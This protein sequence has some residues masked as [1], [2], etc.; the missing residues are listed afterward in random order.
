MIN[1]YLWEIYLKSGGNK[2][3]QFFEDEINANLSM[4]YP[5]KLK[6][7]HKF[8][9][10]DSNAINETYEDLRDLQKNLEFDSTENNYEEKN[11]SKED[12]DLIHKLTLEDCLENFKDFIDE[13]SQVNEAYTDKE[14]FILFSGN[15]SYFSTLL[16]LEKPWL[17]IPYYYKYNFNILERIFVEFEINMPEIPIKR[18]Y[19]SRTYFYAYICYSLLIFRIENDLSPFELCAFLYDFAPKYV[20]GIESYIIS[21]LPEAKGAFLIG[22]SRK[23]R[24]LNHDV[25][26][27][28]IWQSNKDTRPGDMIIMYLTYPDSGIDSFWRSVSAGFIDP[29]FYYYHCTYIEKVEKIKSIPLRTLKRDFVF[30]KIPIVRKNMQGVNGYE[31]KPSEYNYLVDMAESSVP[32]IEFINFTH[33]STIS[34]EKDVENILIKPFLARLGY[35]D[36]DYLQ[37]LTIPVGNHNSMLIPDFVLKPKLSKSHYE[38]FA[39][40]EAKL[41]IRNSKELFEAKKQ[42][43]SYAKQLGTKYSIIADIDNLWIMENKDDYEKIIIKEGRSTLYKDDNFWEIEKMLG[44]DWVNKFI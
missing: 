24:N 38:A 6:I 5:E 17:F 30:G 31:L 35:K 39:V 25:G 40:L 44:F 41:K 4:I 9:C 13:I 22:G 26:S 36:K 20:G 42:V 10:I 11:P 43:R 8:Y 29:F 3:V 34:V 37:Q 19:K 2:I 12:K 1:K 32:K 21:D 33:D 15:M 23:D 27:Y 28:T 14:I 7:F 16:A 18:D